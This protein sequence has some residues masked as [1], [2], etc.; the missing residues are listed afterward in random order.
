MSPTRRVK[1]TSP[2]TRLALTRRHRPHPHPLPLPPLPNEEAARALLVRQRR[3]ALRT[4]ALLGL[5][6][7]GVSGLIAALP[8]LDRHTVAGWPVSWLLLAVAT[9]PLLLLLA[10][11]HVRAAERAE[12]RAGQS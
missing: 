3:L 4:L 1:V 9:Y 5:V 2:Q 6:L 11:T 7:F 10:L 8:A 12:D